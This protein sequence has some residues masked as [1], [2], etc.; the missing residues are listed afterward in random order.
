MASEWCV[1]INKGESVG[2]LFFI[3]SPG[4]AAVLM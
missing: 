4:H 2:D 1:Y 3:V